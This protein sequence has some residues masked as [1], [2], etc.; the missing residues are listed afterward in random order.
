ML[1]AAFSP[2]RDA[3]LCWLVLSLAADNAVSFDVLARRL[4]P[5]VELNL[6]HLGL[7][8]PGG[9][10]IA[11][12]DFAQ[13]DQSVLGDIDQCLQLLSEAFLLEKQVMVEEEL[14]RIRARGVNAILHLFS[15]DLAINPGIKSHQSIPNFEQLLSQEGILLHCQ[16]QLPLV[17]LQQK[18][19][20]LSLFLAGCAQREEDFKAGLALFAH[21]LLHLFTH[22]RCLCFSLLDLM[23]DLFVLGPQCGDD[24]AVVFSFFARLRLS[25]F[26][27]RA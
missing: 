11:S 9:R 20:F 19:V 18:G 4:L 2:L 3:G 15:E 24:F 6:F 10:F 14:P 21:A 16:S 5:E 23:Q 26:S 1:R 17:A 7:R 13:L 8:Q 27:P 12:V 22:A 25:F